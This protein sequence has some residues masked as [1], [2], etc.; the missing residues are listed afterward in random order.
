[1]STFGR[2][3]F[4]LKIYHSNTTSNSHSRFIRQLNGIFSI[5]SFVNLGCSTSILVLFCFM[6]TNVT[7]L[8]D[9][10]QYLMNA[11]SSIVELFVMCYFS[12]KIRDSVSELVLSASLEL[13]SMCQCLFRAQP[14]HKV[15]M[16]A[17]GI[18]KVFDI[19]RVLL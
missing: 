15:C 8:N 17:I 16:K 4:K 1:M 14:S 3:S 5:A 18:L 19:K 2:F 11:F 12:Q 6:G 10:I 13:R 7:S 9:L